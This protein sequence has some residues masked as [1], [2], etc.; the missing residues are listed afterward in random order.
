M[1]V[2]LF[3]TWRVGLCQGCKTMYEMLN[4]AHD[5]DDDD[6]SPEYKFQNYFSVAG[7]SRGGVNGE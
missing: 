6:V 1:S 3:K 4:S 5:D 7:G 2:Q